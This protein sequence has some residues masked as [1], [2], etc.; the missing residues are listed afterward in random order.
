MIG[1]SHTRGSRLLLSAALIASASVCN[2]AEQASPPPN[3]GVSIWAGRVT[4]RGGGPYVPRTLETVR[5]NTYP[6][7]HH[8]HFL[9]NRDPGKPVD[10]RIDEFLHF[11]LSQE[12]HACIEREGRYL[13]L[14]GKMARRQLRKLE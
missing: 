3:S 11:V 10:P 5:D 7:T 2:A 4:S 8:I 9:F 13:P 12:G 6:L 14:S 1:A